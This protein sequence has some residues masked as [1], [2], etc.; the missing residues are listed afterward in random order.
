MHQFQYSSFANKKV[1]L[2]T[3]GARCS[4]GT[5]SRTLECESLSWS[6]S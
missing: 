5:V 3:L 4:T 6:S 2:N 1:V